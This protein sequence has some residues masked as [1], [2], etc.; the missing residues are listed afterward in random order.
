MTDNL[1]QIKCKDYLKTLCVDITERCVGSKTKFTNIIIM[2]IF[3]TFILLGVFL[4]LDAQ[5]ASDI[6]PADKIALQIPD[7]VTN[8]TSGIAGFI[9]SNFSNQK[10]KSRAIFIW[11]AKNVRYDIENMFAINFYQNP[12][13]IVE[14]V[15]S[16]KKGICMHYAE[17]FN[18]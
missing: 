8:T 2:R 1:L 4:G 17:L 16:T 10:D 12:K 15:L 6:F 3:I 14:K 7:S 18:D 9:N 13:E 11:I 5:K